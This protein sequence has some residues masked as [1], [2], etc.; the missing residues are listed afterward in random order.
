MCGWC[1]QA[2]PHRGGATLQ[3]PAGHPARGRPGRPHPRARRLIAPAP[4]A[5]P[6]QGLPASAM[7]GAFVCL[8]CLG[9]SAPMSRD[10]T[11]AESIGLFSNPP[12]AVKI[13]LDEHPPAQDHLETFEPRPPGHVR[14]DLLPLSATY[15]D[16]GPTRSLNARVGSS[17]SSVLRNR[18]ANS[19]MIFMETDGTW[20]F[21]LENSDLDSTS[22]RMSV[23]A[24]T[25]AVRRPPSRRASS[26]KKDPG[27][28][29]ARVT[30][31]REA[32]AWPL[33]ITKNSE[34]PFSPLS[35][36]LTGVSKVL[37]RQRGD[38]TKF[39]IAAL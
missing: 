13:L 2:A 38:S 26:P 31:S 21:R 7:I 35:Q 16:H 8:R 25:V 23:S 37:R 19:S 15:S 33:T 28:R 10:R 22:S 4:L 39:S 11:P 20:R 12:Q 36:D 34:P 32:V 14:R 27:P 18:A 1:Y 6:D 5:R 3:R 24:T 9:T 29:V 17:I 30:P